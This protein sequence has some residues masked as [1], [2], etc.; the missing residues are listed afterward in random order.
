MSAG[1]SGA[2]GCTVELDAGGWC[3]T[4]S[5]DT[6]QGWLKAAT[7]WNRQLR[8]SYCWLGPERKGKQNGR[9]SL[10]PCPGLL[11]PFAENPNRK[12][13]D[14][15]HLE[16][17]LSKSQCRQAELRRVGLELRDSGQLCGGHMAPQHRTCCAEPETQVPAQ[18]LQ[19]DLQGHHP[20][21]WHFLFFNFYFVLEYG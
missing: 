9:Q 3:Q 10:I 7:G 2:Q 14:K 4:I 5:E 13:A 18:L 19:G 15:R 17:V 12:M 11:G 6:V 16:F 20:G 1:A 21:S 8:L